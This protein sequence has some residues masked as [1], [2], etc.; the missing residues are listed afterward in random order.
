MRSLLDELEGVERSELVAAARRRRFR[1]NEIIFH[2][3]DP[4]GS[5]HVVVKGHVAIRITSR[6]GDVVTLNVLGPGQAFGELALL[7][8]DATRTASAVSLDPSETLS[9]DRAT[10]QR[11]RERSADFDRFFIEVL[12]EAVQRLSRQLMEAYHLS[13]E[14][15]VLARLSGLAELFRPGEEVVAIPVTQEDLASI[16][17]TTRPTV[18]R[19]LKEAEAKGLVVLSRGRI[20]VVDR[21]GL[22]GRVR[23]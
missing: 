10:V 19:V 16:A 23:A 8:E 22:A 3:G 6:L 17:G 11:F 9:W 14:Q 21:A 2:E 1:R 5:L 18:N 12:A 13:V 20:E 15:R 7:N 4:G